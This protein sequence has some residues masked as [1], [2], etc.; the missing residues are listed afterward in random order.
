MVDFNIRIVIDTSGARAGVGRVNRQLRGVEDS[1]DRIRSLARSA[2]A[3]A[4]LGLGARETVRLIDSFT[5][6][7]NRLRVVSAD[8]NVLTNNTEALLE[9]S[10]RTR[11]SF[12]R[13][14]ELFTRTSL[15]TRQLGLSQRDTLQFT[16]SLNQAVILSGATVQEA[17]AGLI[18]FSQ[19][20][21]AGALRGDELRS[22]LEQLPVIA[23]IIAN[24]LGVLRGDL[25]ELAAES[26]ISADIIIRAFERVE[27]N[28]ASAFGQTVPTIAQALQ[29]LENN[30]TNLVGQFGEAT[31]ALSSGLLLIA[32]N[33][34][35]VGE[36]LALIALA[37]I[38]DSGAAA[39]NRFNQV[40][41]V[42]LRLVRLLRRAFLIGFAIEAIEELT[43]RYFQFAQIVRQTPATITDALT[44]TADV[45]LNNFINVFRVIGRFFTTDLVNLLVET[46]SQGFA[47]ANVTFEDILTGDFDA[48]LVES[49][50]SLSFEVAFG[51]IADRARA[52]LEER[53]LQIA[54]EEQLAQFGFGVPGAV[55]AEQETIPESRVT[56]DEPGPLT[57][58]LAGFE[59]GIQRLRQQIPLMEQP[60]QALGRAVADIFGPDGTLVQGI[61]DGTAEAIVFGE[62]FSSILADLGRQI[63]ADLLS[64]LL[65]IGLNFGLGAILPGGGGVGAG[66]GGGAGGLLGFAQGGS[67]TV[68]SG[69]SPSIGGLD[70][71]L[72]QFRAR[73]GER[74]TITPPGRPDPGMA[75]PSMQT[76]INVYPSPGMD[77]QQVAD[78][79]DQRIRR[80]QQF[81][82]TLE[83]NPLSRSRRG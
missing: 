14:A 71:R 82:G 52:T 16:E 32:N 61:A 3:F 5:R 69:T 81:G 77:E 47:L 73:D 18:Q 17:Q 25:R 76:T 22:V 12:E 83:R 38:F 31:N 56:A 57:E 39:A 42:T 50:F 43:D 63:V 13:T 40:L 48:G 4:G 36:V 30:L 45:I 26:P 7:Q 75:G 53:L 10:N 23:D 70:N 11:S 80:Q 24:E 37:A 60:F 64:Q 19:G 35:T 34:E 67:F 68:G 65:R 33:L 2:F 79:V 62:S 27:G 51:R 20:L 15:A 29:V 8:T 41:T 55:A 9:I 28:L 78:L 74:V 46:L 59:D 49:A 66:G 1:L 54:T 44:V 21:S 72:V 6:L 58:F